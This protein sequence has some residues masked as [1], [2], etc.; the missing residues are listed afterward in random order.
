MSFESYNNCIVWKALWDINKPTALKLFY[1]CTESKNTP[2]N[3]DFL[4]ICSK[5]KNC[6][7][8]SNS[9]NFNLMVRFCHDDSPNFSIKSF[10]LNGRKRAIEFKTTNI[11]KV[12]LKFYPI[13]LLF[14]VIATNLPDLYQ[15]RTRFSL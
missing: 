12:D 4:L 9:F 7:L 8:E 10:Y 6:A 11:D 14:G 13:Q 3:Q 2:D 5:L 15:L 1:C